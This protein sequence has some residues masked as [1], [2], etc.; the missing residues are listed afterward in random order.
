M[1]MQANMLKNTFGRHKLVQTV[2]GCF[3]VRNSNLEG[4]FG[5]AGK[6]F[7]KYVLE[8][9][10]APGC[11]RVLL[12]LK[13]IPPRWPGKHN[14]RPPYS[15]KCGARLGESSRNHENVSAK[16]RSPNSRRRAPRGPNVSQ[17]VMLNVQRAQARCKIP[18]ISEF[19]P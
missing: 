5:A 1:G 3:C 14:Q 7:Q 10:T 13:P 18:E 12:K 16:R 9:Q 4:R 2:G 11:G 6:H 8:P 19:G 15:S 17:E